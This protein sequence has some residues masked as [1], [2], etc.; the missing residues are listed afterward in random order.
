MWSWWF[1]RLWLWLRR[2][3]LVP[4]R[5]V[6][7]RP[8]L[9][10]GTI[11]LCQVSGVSEDDE[12]IGRGAAWPAVVRETA[13][14]TERKRQL[15]R[16]AQLPSATPS[17]MVS[18]L[19][20]EKESEQEPEPKPSHADRR[21]A[22]TKAAM[23]A[24]IAAIRRI[25]TAG[26][27]PSAPEPEPEPEQEPEPKPAEEYMQLSHADRRAAVTKAAM[28]AGIAAIRR[29]P[30][31][32]AG[33]SAPEPEPEPEQ[34][35]NERLAAEQAER[36]CLAVEHAA[37]EWLAAEQATQEWLAD[38]SAQQG[39]FET[40][41]QEWLS[42]E[43]AAQEQLAAHST[44]RAQTA[45]DPIWFEEQEARRDLHA[46]VVESMH[47]TLDLRQQENLAARRVT[48][49]NVI[50]CLQHTMQQQK[51]AANA[52]KDLDRVH[53]SGRSSQVRSSDCR[54]CVQQP[55][56]MTNFGSGESGDD[57]SGGF[58]AFLGQ[59]YTDLG[60]V[61]QRSGFVELH[62]LLH[63]VLS[64]TSSA[65]ADSLPL[66]GQPIGDERGAL[67][68]MA[69]TSEQTRAGIKTPLSSMETSSG[70]DDDD[71]DDDDPI[72]G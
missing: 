4:T 15:Q 29:I 2:S 21:A 61:T 64:D 46:S 8:P 9:S 62:Q 51:H 38:E 40:T 14:E 3:L 27:G 7:P 28:S 34:T 13:R 63:S 68:V 44:Q 58:H 17:L 36:E 54:N 26:A 16:G 32:G 5:L 30:T 57:G 12:M 69:E 55:Q 71:D 1:W 35:E 37:Q 23:S 24:G 33:P 66:T 43:Q 6:A 41:E 65:V 60:P 67:V 50:E 56:S 52:L 47:R 59:L 10:P 45:R 31:A 18:T 53:S 70:D 42:D 72:A 22:V 25:P 49:A 20:L 48:H 39:W 11:K 19:D